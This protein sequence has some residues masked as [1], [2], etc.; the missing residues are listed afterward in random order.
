MNL[1]I[2]AALVAGAASML[3][4]GAWAWL[5]PA[6]FA[7]FANWPNHVHFLHDAGVFQIGIGVTMLCALRWRDPISL[8]LAGFVV[9]TALHAVNHAIDLSLGGRSSDFWLLLAL[10]AV[11]LVAWVARI[12][13][14]RA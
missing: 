14:V 8:V 2:K 4:F 1:L 13:Q 12:R 7:R 5:D 3:V 10:A 11:G 6:G 9:T